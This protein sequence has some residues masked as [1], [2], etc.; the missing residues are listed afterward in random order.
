M[1]IFHVK[2]QCLAVRSWSEAVKSTKV[3]ANARAMEKSCD[4]LNRCNITVKCS[5]CDQ[6]LHDGDELVELKF[7]KL[8]S[9]EFNEIVDELYCHQH[10]HGVDSFDGNIKYSYF[11]NGPRKYQCFVSNYYLLLN[12]DVCKNVNR[13]NSSLLYCCK[14]QQN[15]GCVDIGPA[16][17]YFPRKSCYRYYYTSTT[18]VG[19]SRVTFEEEAVEHNMF[20]NSFKSKE[21]YLAW[22]IMTEVEENGTL[23]C[24]VKSLD[25][26]PRLLVSNIWVLDP[27]VVYACGKL[28]NSDATN[29]HGKV[30]PFPAVKCLYKR[31]KDSDEVDPFLRCQQIGGCVNIYLPDDAIDMLIECLDN[32]CDE[33]PSICRNMGSNFKAGFLPSACEL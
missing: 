15:I 2:N 18:L 23:H 16:N 30:S 33:L 19:K 29:Q 32:N 25:N 13:E 21:Q 20:T 8:P 28:T 1:S 10:Y 9:C 27:F 14:C 22:L 5:K 11:M 26:H 6:I 4:L 7:F 3:R 24:I 31:M 12:A 17:R